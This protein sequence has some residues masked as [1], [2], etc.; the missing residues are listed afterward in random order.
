VAEGGEGLEHAGAI[1]SK[2][3]E[4]HDGGMQREGASLGH[5]LVEYEDGKGE[6][7]RLHTTRQRGAVI[8]GRGERTEATTMETHPS[9]G[10]TS[11]VTA[12]NAEIAHR[13][14]TARKRATW[15]E[16]IDH[17]PCAST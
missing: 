16:R 10:L 17:P 11:D 15:K 4:G 7:I 8:R 6:N 9:D 12:V 3:G 13:A 14:A 5:R 1:D 2:D